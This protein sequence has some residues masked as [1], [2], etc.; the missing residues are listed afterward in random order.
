MPTDP[1]Y[2]IVAASMIGAMIGFLARGLFVGNEVRRANTEGWKEGS[3]F[4]ARKEAEMRRAGGSDEGG[5]W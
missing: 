4:Y 1:M 2:Y 3:R 5:V